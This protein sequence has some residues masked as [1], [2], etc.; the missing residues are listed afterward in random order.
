LI[1]G[2][3]LKVKPEDSAAAIGILKQPENFEAEDSEE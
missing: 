2:I 1:G 3:K